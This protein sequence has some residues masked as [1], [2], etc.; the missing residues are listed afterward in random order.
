MQGSCG[1]I[2]GGNRGESIGPDR[3]FTEIQLAP[4]GKH[5][6]VVIPDPVSGNRDIWLMEMTTGTL[7]RITSHP[8][9]DWQVAWTADSREIAFASDRNGKSSVY[10]KTIDG[11]GEEQLLLR[12]PD[13][14]AFPKDFSVDGRFLTLGVD[15]GSGRSGIWALPLFGDRRPFQLLQTTV[16]A[17]EPMLSSDGEW[18]AYES[19]ESGTIEIYVKP[20]TRPNKV[21]VSSAGGSQPR[22]RGDGTELFYTTPTGDVMSAALVRR[23]ETIEAAASV[24]LFAACANVSPGTQVV[25]GS[26]ATYDVAADGERLLF[27]C[28]VPDAT[29]PQVTV[30]VDWASA[31]K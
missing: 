23:G 22:W 1:S 25:A 15:S 18:V 8:A 20:F 28:A 13:S 12:L 14:G 11:G 7:T 27:A 6:T 17:N 10:R 16:R 3:E 26:R 9:N 31:L 30:S 29:P 19:S 21:R 4:D 5:A 24:R 2:V